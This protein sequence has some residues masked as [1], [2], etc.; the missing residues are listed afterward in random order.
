PREPCRPGF[1]PARCSGSSFLIATNIT[2][3]RSANS[4]SSG[5]EP[6]MNIPMYTKT[7]YYASSHCSH[8]LTDDVRISSSRRARHG[9][10]LQAAG[11]NSCPTSFCQEQ[12]YWRAYR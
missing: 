9:S 1:T 11:P 12:C 6:Q 8:E 4:T 5:L 7:Y 10:I 3:W 2:N